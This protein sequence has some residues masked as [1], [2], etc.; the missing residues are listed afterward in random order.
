MKTEERKEKKE[1]KREGKR[2]QSAFPRCFLKL[3]QFAAA[4]VESC[5]ALVRARAIQTRNRNAYQP[6]INRKLRAVMNHVIHAHAADTRDSRERENLLA[7]GKQLPSFHDFFIADAGERRSS[8]RAAFVKR[9][10]KLFPVRDLRRLVGRSISRARNPALRVLM[11]MVIHS[12]NRAHV[13]GKPAHACRT[14]RAASNSTCR[15]DTRSSDFARVLHLFVKFGQHRLS[16]GHVGLH[17]KVATQRRK[18]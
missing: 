13:P 9:C 2:I 12:G 11:V 15:R 8:F 7:T 14:S 3:R 5:C 6:E 17:L 16:N 1:K 4:A 18:S 10:K